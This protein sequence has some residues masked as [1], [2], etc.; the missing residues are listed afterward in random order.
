[1]LQ[2]AVLLWTYDPAERDAK[3]ANEVLNSKKKS[4]KHLQ[5]LVE[6]ACA[7]SPHHL[8]AV[9]KAYRDRFYCSL[10]EEIISSVPSALRKVRYFCWSSSV[11][12][13]LTHLS[14]ADQP[15]S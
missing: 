7:S 1:M 4:I 10:E 15:V 14:Y 11:T 8:I 6:I 3:L 5:V 2:K 13:C 9:R 12:N